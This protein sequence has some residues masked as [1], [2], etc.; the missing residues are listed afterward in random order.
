[1]L[2]LPYPSIRCSPTYHLGPENVVSISTLQ[3]RK[4]LTDGPGI[5]RS[6]SAKEFK[7]ALE[8]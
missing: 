4:L 2:V 7:A 1:M 6:V 3:C 8:V 5:C